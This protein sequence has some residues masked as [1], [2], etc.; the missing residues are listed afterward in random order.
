[1]CANDFSKTQPPWRMKRHLRSS[2][3]GLFEYSRRAEPST[4]RQRPRTHMPLQYLYCL[5]SKSSVRLNKLPIA[6]NVFSRSCWWGML[7]IITAHNY[8]ICP[9]SGTHWS[10]CR[11]QRSHWSGTGVVAKHLLPRSLSAEGL[12]WK[13]SLR[14]ENKRCWY[15]FRDCWDESA[16]GR[17]ML[18]VDSAS[19][20]WGH[21][22]T[23]I[24]VVQIAMERCNDDFYCRS[25][26]WELPPES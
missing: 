20:I 21:Q 3:F 16:H 23:R 13:W 24:R 5:S 12:R 14:F 4:V 17:G 2:Y 15:G 6:Q 11:L 7:F 18:G 22:E 26:C 1:M 19:V 25:L 8:E 10:T 9:A